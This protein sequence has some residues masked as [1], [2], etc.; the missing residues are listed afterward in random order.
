[1]TGD[2]RDVGAGDGKAATASAALADLRVVGAALAR[3]FAGAARFGPR[4]VDEAE[5]V[6]SVLLAIAC[7]H[8]LGGT[9]VGW[10]AFS[11][12]MVMRSH[13]VESLRRGILRVVGTGAGAALA[14]LLAGELAAGVPGAGAAPSLWPPLLAS[15][16][17]AAVGALT[18]YFALVG[19][20]GYAWL[21]TG[22]TFCMVLIDAVQH[23]GS[24]LS[25]AVARLTEVGIGTA[26]CVLVSAVSTLTLRRALGPVSRPAIAWRPWLPWHRAAAAHALQAGLALALIPWAWRWLGVS[27]LSQSSITIM[28]VMMVPAAS[29]A[30][31]PGAHATIS[32]RLLHRFVGCCAGGLVATLAL[33]LT[34]HQPLAMAVAVALGVAA[35][36]HVENGPV[37]IAYVGTQFV[38]AF[39]VVLVPDSYADAGV[40]PG[41]QRLFGILFGMVL[42]EPVLLA[43]RY[44]PRLG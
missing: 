41:L 15:A 22:L 12:Y 5:A 7:A 31:G 8:R 19:R 35:G 18:L 3:D 1:M 39:L 27:A 44:L 11:G 43:F 21:F 14:W 42:L 32:T 10:A 36:R 2:K 20:Y 40:G 23:P 25:F 4:L 6:L 26:A 30:S 37:G 28:A 16:A 24:A 33:L 9:N 38:L 29:L 17:L 13:V 34:H